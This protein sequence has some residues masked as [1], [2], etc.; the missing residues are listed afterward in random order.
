[1]YRQTSGSI[2]RAGLVAWVKRLFHSALW[3]RWEESSDVKAAYSVSVNKLLET[4][5]QR[6]DLEKKLKLDFGPENVFLTLADRLL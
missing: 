3:E 1:M 5:K 4:T 6:K 2:C